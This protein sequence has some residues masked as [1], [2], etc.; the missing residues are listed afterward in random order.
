MSRVIVVPALARAGHDHVSSALPR[1]S[2]QAITSRV[3]SDLDRVFIE[4]S[5]AD[6]GPSR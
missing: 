6:A 1:P 4:E 2:A 3:G 5:R